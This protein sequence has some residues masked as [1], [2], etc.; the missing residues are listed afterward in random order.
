MLKRINLISSHIS[1]GV[2]IL[3]PVEIYKYGAVLIWIVPVFFINAIIVIYV[4]APILFK[5]EVA[6]IF[7]YLEKRFDTKTKLLAASFYIIQETIMLAFINSTS[8]VI[9]GTS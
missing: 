9:L 7:E 1:G 3:V 8:A 5:A 2:L 4:F 6:S